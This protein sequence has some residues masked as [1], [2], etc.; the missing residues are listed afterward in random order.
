MKKTDRDGEEIEWVRSQ[1]SSSSS[2][3]TP[4]YRPPSA[5]HYYP[6][7]S[8]RPS[9][10]HSYSRNKEVTHPARRYLEIYLYKLEMDEYRE[11]SDDTNEF[12]LLKFRY[13]FC[14]GSCSV[15]LKNGKGKI[16]VPLQA[17]EGVT[18]SDERCLILKFNLG[19]KNLVSR[20]SPEIRRRRW[21]RQ[22]I[23]IEE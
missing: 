6:S 19:A 10:R 18:K 2:T 14:K 13:K 9:Y 15:F 3:Y 21:E 8:P 23:A 22:R 11:M 16:H 4:R 7:R 1:S 12:S 17:L 20:P 5:T